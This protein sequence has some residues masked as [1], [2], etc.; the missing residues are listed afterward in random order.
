MYCHNCGKY[1]G[2]SKYCPECGANLTQGKN[3]NTQSPY[4]INRDPN[5]VPAV[6]QKKPIYKKWWFWVIIV[7]V[8][9]SIAGKT[10]STKMTPSEAAEKLNSEIKT[11]TSSDTTRSRSTH[12]DTKSSNKD[13]NSKKSTQKEKEN[14]ETLEEIDPDIP[15][16]TTYE[17][18]QGVYVCGSD[19]PAGRYLIEW[20]DGNQFGGY[21]T[22]NSD[23]KYLDSESI[24]KENNYTC[25]L[26]AGDEFEV[27][28]STFRFTKITSLPNSNYLES[29]GS[30]VF[31]QGYFFEGIDIPEGKYN[32]TA[33]GGNPYGIYISTYTKSFISLDQEETYRNLKLDTPGK[34]IKISLGTA[35]FE[36][37]S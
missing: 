25:I 33:I 12:K 10:V 32:V 2:D 7:L 30:Y 20:V 6:S 29:D 15:L 13:T 16:G 27:S 37:T 35:K 9:A 14:T 26:S 36:P 1:V 18:S 17:L 23:C 3:D 19:I 22:D 24:D 21:I 8:V 11:S 28:L 31:G 4:F 5:T 34:E